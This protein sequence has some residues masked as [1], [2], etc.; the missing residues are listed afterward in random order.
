VDTASV[1][2]LVAAAGAVA[3]AFVA[4]RRT[5]ARAR[6]PDARAPA[7]VVAE[8]TRAGESAA[9]E[10][11][12]L[13]HTIV[14]HAPMA[15]LVF[16][17]TGRV[18]FSNEEARLLFAAG[19]PLEGENFLRLLER[20]PEALRE[21]LLRETDVVFALETEHGSETFGLARR[22][23]ELDG[24]AHTLVMLKELTP[25][26]ER[27]ELDVW[28]KVIRIINHEL[29]NSLAPI[30]SMAQ[31]ARIIVKDPTQLSKLDLVF[32]TIEERAA[33]L[34]AFLAGYASIA[35]LPRPRQQNVSWATFLDGFRA[36]YPDITILNAPP[37]DGFFDPGQL[38]QVVINL[39]KNAREASQGSTGIELGVRG[40]DDGSAT[41]T[42]ADRGAG[43]SDETLK[44]AL[45]P[46]FSTKERGTGLGLALAQEILEAHRGKL[47]L[48]RREGGGIEVS[49]WLPG[50]QRRARP[51]TQTLTLTRG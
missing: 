17:Q 43:M 38:Q 27:Q 49:C 50:T 51:R 19:A 40:G 9:P 7:A 48:A 1:F 18:A 42:V 15:V 46:F 2:L 34:S 47:S 10:R 41:L 37:G 45:L 16:G 11:N 5:G 29:N 24:E 26:L 8:S 25:E 3:L 13:L 36:L 22:Q 20:A 44:S 14:E 4:G 39:L 31:T 12:E 28:K 6:T 33:H 23:V 32:S 35:R 21:G 30:L